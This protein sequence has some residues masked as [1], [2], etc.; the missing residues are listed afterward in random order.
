MKSDLASTVNWLENQTELLTFGLSLL[1]FA[2]IAFLWFLG[3]LRD[4]MGY[5]EDQFFSTLF[6]G[7]GILYIGMVFVASAFAGG[8]LVAFSLEP[9]LLT[10]NVVLLVTRSITNQIIS[11]YAIRMAGM[12]M[13]VLGTI[14]NR[15]ELMPRWLIII[16]YGFALILLI[17]IGFTH[18]VTLIFPAWV[19][20]ISAY[21]LYLNYLIKSEQ[22]D[23]DGLT[24]EN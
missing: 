9:E 16:T 5:L 18:W 13:I 17:S 21:I 23:S 19:L 20:L 4:R 22:I 11:I 8:S 10:N 1:P 7:S 3:V 6:L 2:G 24:V 14:W 12:F 15:T